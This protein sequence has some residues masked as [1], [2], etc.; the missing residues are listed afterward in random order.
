MGKGRVTETNVDF[1][2]IVNIRN[3]QKHKE[4]EGIGKGRDLEVKVR[5]DGYH[6][7]L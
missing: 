3:E 5:A 4:K 2:I 1:Y 6:R 7:L